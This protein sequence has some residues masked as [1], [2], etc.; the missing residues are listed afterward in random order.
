VSV[1]A[2]GN[3]SS[4][5]GFVDGSASLARFYNPVNL[6]IKKDTAGNAKF[7]YVVDQSNHAIRRIEAGTGLVS[8]VVGVPETLTNW[9][10]GTSIVSG[11]LNTTRGTLETTG[12]AGVYFPKGLGITT[13]GDL[14]V[15]SGDGVLQITAPEGK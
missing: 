12:T 13:F 5:S 2:G 14:I 4:A 11:R 8:T 6:A 3:A 15:T 1:V 10:N 9:N 7:I